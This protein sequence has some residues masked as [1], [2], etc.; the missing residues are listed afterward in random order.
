MKRL[1]LL[2]LIIA[3]MVPVTQIGTAQSEC[4]VPTYL[5]TT[6]DN[7]LQ[8]IADVE[9]D[10]ETGLPSRL[11]AANNNLADQ[12]E[13]LS[14][15]QIPRCVLTL[16]QLQSQLLI[17]TQEEV[18][19]NEL[20]LA[21]PG[22]AS[23]VEP[24]LALSIQ[25]KEGLLR[26]INAEATRLSEAAPVATVER[27]SDTWY[28]I[29]FTEVINSDAEADHFGA[30]IEDSALVFLIDNAE[31]TIDAAL[32]E[33][34]APETTEALLRAAARG[35][36][37]RMVVDD[38]FAFEDPESTIQELIDVGVDVINDDRSA[39]MHHKYFIFDGLTVWTGSTNITRNGLY[40]NNNNAMAIQ[41]PQIVANYQ[42]EFNEMFQDNFFTR[43]GDPRSVPFRDIT[44]DDGT[45][46]ETY[47]MPE[48]GNL[49][50]DRLVNLMSNAQ[51]SIKIMTFNFTLE[52]VAIAMAQ[53]LAN[54]V[55]VSGVWETLGS[56][57]GQMVP[58]ACVGADVRQ[59]G[60]PDILHHKVLIV[61]DEI[62]VTGSMNFSNNARDNNSEN[63][64][65]IYNADIA[66]DYVREFEARFAEGRIPDLSGQ[67]C[68]RG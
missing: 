7:T 67:D 31:S 57:Q 4:D 59:D 60:N 20:I 6:L 30:F 38:E 25:R 3:A 9:A 35:V 1:L 62:V 29:Y 47:F 68:G 58:L 55:S 26:Q 24:L 49:V 41:L 28:R 11:L 51:S 61:D 53:R 65:I 63:V 48:D 14:T 40:N 44:L 16:H 32:Y 18:G 54:G 13:F 23:E 10:I 52:P 46:I 50:Q 27:P 45:R 15:L 33:L 66:A 22:N 37:I 64:V 8:L 43:R 36:T 19:L 42:A 17:E 21:E 34:N 2:C 56:L 5:N 12:R 39:L